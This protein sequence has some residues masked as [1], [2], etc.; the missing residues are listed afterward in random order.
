MELED[1]AA[2]VN[3]GGDWHMPSPTQIKELIN[4]TTSEWTTLDGVSGMSFT[5]KKDKSK[6]I[7]IPAAGC[8]LDG[9][10]DGSGYYGYVWSSMLSTDFVDDGHSVRGVIG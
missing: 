8:A 6:F 1:D 9:L 7:F 5:S 3:M 2:H 4:E 10:V